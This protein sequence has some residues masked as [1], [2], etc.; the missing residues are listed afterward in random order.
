MK[1][2][3]RFIDGMK[4]PETE[5]EIRTLKDSIKDLAER[6]G[7]LLLKIAVARAI[8]EIKAQPSDMEQIIKRALKELENLI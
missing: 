4:R 2:K 1:G 7:E 6:N 5:M 3:I 8:L